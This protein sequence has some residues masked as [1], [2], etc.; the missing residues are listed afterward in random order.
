MTGRH[1]FLFCK[2]D[3][4]S[5]P[6]RPFVEFISRDTVVEEEEDV[7]WSDSFIRLDRY[8]TRILLLLAIME[9]DLLNKLMILN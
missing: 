7:K 3:A 1:E 8:W 6:I 5:N 9:D 2:P 4:H